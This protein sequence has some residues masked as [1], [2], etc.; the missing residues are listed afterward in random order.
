M[1]FGDAT[2]AGGAVGQPLNG[3]IVGGARTPSGRGYWLAGADGGVYAYGDAAF[4]GSAAEVGRLSS[5][6]VGIA[7]T[8]TGAG[9]WLAG[10]DGGVFAFG[11][12]EFFGSTADQPPPVPVQDLIPA[13]S[14]RGYWLVR[15]DREVVA[16][17]AVDAPMQRRPG[18]G[19]AIMLI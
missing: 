6:I 13:P 16:F 17:G 9:Y 11:D 10:A 2:Y 5:P 18:I 19:P 7:A 3:A 4:F 8:A 1:A 15:A 12:A 14:G